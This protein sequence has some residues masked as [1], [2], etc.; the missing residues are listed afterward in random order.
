MEIEGLWLGHDDLDGADGR[1]T[2]YRVGSAC[3]NRRAPGVHRIWTR[4]FGRFV[5]L[6]GRACGVSYIPTSQR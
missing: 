1:D 5:D 3:A 4:L 2:R 6:R